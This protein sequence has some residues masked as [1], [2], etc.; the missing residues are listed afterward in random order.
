LTVPLNA[1]V[2]LQPTAQTATTGACGPALGEPEADDLE[3]SYGGEF[4]TVDLGN[5]RIE[6]NVVLK[7]RTHEMYAQL[8]MQN[9]INCC[10]VVEKPMP[11]HCDKHLTHTSY[12]VM[13][14]KRVYVTNN[15]ADAINFIKST[16]ATHFFVDNEAHAGSINAMTLHPFGQMTTLLFYG[17]HVNV[18]QFHVYSTLED[19]RC[20]CYS[21]DT[22]LE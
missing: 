16:Q 9:R 13:L 20:T 21:W 5:C 12:Y 3:S 14:T 11:H 4:L 2:A 18:E 17:P 1:V 19:L 7:G 6:A 15:V 10:R 8:A 22:N